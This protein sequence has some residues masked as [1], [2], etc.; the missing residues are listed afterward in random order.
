MR[1]WHIPEGC[2]PRIIA[3]TRLLERFKQKLKEISK[4]KALVLFASLL[5]L[6]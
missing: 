4:E 1:G 3:R 2:R 6:T 5:H